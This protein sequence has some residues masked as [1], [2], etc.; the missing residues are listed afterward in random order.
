MDHR[1]FAD[2]DQFVT[3]WYDAQT[4]L[5]QNQRDIVHASLH[6]RQSL[7]EIAQHHGITRERARQVANQGLTRL[8]DQARR[9][10][11]NP[12]CAAIVNADEITNMAG[13]ELALQRI[14]L[15]PKQQSAVIRQLTNIGAIH[16]NEESWGLAILDAMPKPAQPRPS[17]RRL[18]RDARQ[19][20]GQHRNGATP[21]HI[22]RHLTHWHDAFTQWP[23]L[24]LAL[25]IQAMTTIVPLQATGRYHPVMGWDIRLASDPHFTVHYTAKALEHANRCL[26]VKETLQIANQIA[27]DDG[28]ERPITWWQ[29]LG[30]LQNKPDFKW[31][32]PSKYG[33]SSWPVGHSDPGNQRGLRLTLSD[34]VF[35]L[36]EQ[37]PHP[38]PITELQ[39][40]IRKRFEV[41]DGAL[42]TALYKEAD[43]DTLV[44]NP[45]R[46]VS[47]SPQDADSHS[48]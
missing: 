23:K 45:D 21:H 43:R 1:I 9:D 18:A 33:L 24:N 6:D 26:T 31:V 13:L 19:I 37:S 11:R 47:L 48:I 2:L 10:T 27:R 25:H 41:T 17:L 20:A 32:G 3:A 16:S 38:L 15:S 7:V 35:H 8:L 46:T 12:V 30:T 22:R 42:I 39:E 4:N 29:V 36:L 5:T 14:R 40:H 34:E 44:I 28:F